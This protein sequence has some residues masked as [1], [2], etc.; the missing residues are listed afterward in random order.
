MSAGWRQR[1]VESSYGR[2]R[3]PHLV[4]KALESNR[5]A[6]EDSSKWCSFDLVW[7]YDAER[8]LVMLVQEG[9]RF[10]KVAQEYSEDKAKGTL[11]PGFTFT[12]CSDTF[13]ISWRK[14]WVDGS[15]FDGGTFSRP[16]SCGITTLNV[17]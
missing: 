6:A 2:E 11:K 13:C 4:R 15:R 3:A 17:S 7:N 9:Q 12:K 14:S 10:D 16:S 5:G 1:R 8:R